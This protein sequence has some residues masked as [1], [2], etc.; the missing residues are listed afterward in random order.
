MRVL[1]DTDVIS[2]ALRSDPR[3]VQFYAPELARAEPFVSFMTIGELEHGAAL[4]NWGT[5]RV[6]EMR[7][8]LDANFSSVMATTGICRRW[9]QLMATAKSKGRVLNPPDGW[10]AAT[11]VHY[12]IPLMTN[13]RRDF[14]YLPG[15]SLITLDGDS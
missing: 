8:Y 13:N 12:N 14:E 15:L 7:A 11:A 1:V 3:F 5:R 9:G 2:Y 4:R 10:I 6:G